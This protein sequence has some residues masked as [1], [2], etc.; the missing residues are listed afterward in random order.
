MKTEEKYLLQLK[1][2]KLEETFKGRSCMNV[3]NTKMMD[4]KI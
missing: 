4:I 1:F 2:K 3:D